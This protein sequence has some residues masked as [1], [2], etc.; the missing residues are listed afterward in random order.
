M[1]EAVV[2][3]SIDTAGLHALVPLAQTLGLRVAVAAPD[4]VT[5]ELD[6][7]PELCTAGGVLHGGAVMALADTAGA[8]CAYL[9]LPEGA[10]GTTTVE[11]KT[12]L[13][14]A[15]RGGTLAASATPL[16]IGSRLVVVETEL[17]RDDG[18]LAAKTTQTQA[19]L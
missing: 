6:H 10:A 5:L 17:R 13:L 11:S 19:V 4:A 15:V 3:P 9:N 12:N 18:R 14:A 2:M 8:L 7:R 16:H 1:R